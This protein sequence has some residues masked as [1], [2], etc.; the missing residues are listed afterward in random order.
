MAADTPR[1]RWRQRTAGH[2]LVIAFAVAMAVP[3]AA[4]ALAQAAPGAAALPGVGS[5]GPPDWV[6]PGTRVSFHGSA[7]AIT[8]DASTYVE[9]PNGPWQDPA[10]GKHYSLVEPTGATT[11]GGGGD[12]ISQLDVLAIDGNDVVVS[13]S[14]YAIDRINSVFIAP[15]VSGGREPGAAASGAWVS[16]TWLAQLDPASLGGLLVLRGDFVL[17]GTTYHAVSLVRPT[18]GAYASDTYDTQ[19]GVLLAEDTQT[20][21][22]QGGLPGSTLLTQTHYIGT[23]QRMIPGLG[24]IDPEWVAT[25]PQLTYSGTEA[26]TNPLV[27]SA[28]AMTAPM[29]VTVTLAP[30][31]RDWETYTQDVEVDLAGVTPQHTQTSGATGTTGIYWWDTATLATLRPGQLIDQ[32]PVTTE[33]VTVDAVGPGPAGQAVTIASHKPGIDTRATYDLATGVLVAFDES[34]PVAGT[35]YSLQLDSLP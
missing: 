21:D 17:D 8:G 30:G 1:A 6:K 18:P 11:S 4:P 35:T 29:H 24:G 10:T 25:T 32:D 9:D 14:S 15:S 28:G 26:I 2:A 13:Q 3:A 34:L 5:F 19:T 20:P 23:R 27:P 7:A 33:R 31:G 22:T 16:P 12:G